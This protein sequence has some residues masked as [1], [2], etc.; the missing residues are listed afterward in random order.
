MDIEE[1]SEEE[2]G[3]E[4]EEEEEADIEEKRARQ[5]S[6]EDLPAGKKQQLAEEGRKPDNVARNI[7][8]QRVPNK[9]TAGGFPRRKEV[10]STAAQ[11]A[12]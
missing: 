6:E 7:P 11:K 1:I 10:A 12:I 2:S 4:L 8:V 3:D 5:T 9:Y